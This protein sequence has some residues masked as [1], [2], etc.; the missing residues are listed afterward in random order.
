MTNRFYNLRLDGAQVKL[1]LTLAGQKALRE[2]YH[3][4][5]IET[6]LGAATDCGR[7]ASLLDAALNWQG[8]DNLI[9]EG[10]ALYNRLVDEGWCGQEQF[11]GLA[12]DIAYYSGIF[13]EAQAHWLKDSIHR[14][15]EEVF[16]PVDQEEQQP[17]EAPPHPAKQA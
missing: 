2:E 11:G 13:T 4:E 3:E 14:T 5:I 1:R 12:F 10:E 7:L 17:G 6:V 9:R 16:Q 8:N 15:V